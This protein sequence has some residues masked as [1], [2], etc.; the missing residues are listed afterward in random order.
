M[1]SPTT[2]KSKQ[3][4]KTNYKSATTQRTTTINIPKSKLSER[5]ITASTTTQKTRATRRK[6]ILQNQRFFSSK[7]PSISQ[8]NRDP[9][10]GALLKTQPSVITSTYT[11][12]E[13]P[14]YS[15]I[16]ATKKTKLATTPSP[17]LTNE[18]V[19][20]ATSKRPSIN[21]GTRVPFSGALLI[22]QPSVIT[23]STTTEPPHYLIIDTT[24]KT[25]LA[26]T[27]SPKLTNENV[28]KATTLHPKIQSKKDSLPIW[29]AKLATTPSQKL[30]IENV[31]KATFLYPNIEP[32]RDSFPIWSAWKEFGCK[33]D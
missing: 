22:T 32:K 9:F 18:N 7:R 15:I 14:H 2:P 30:T 31:R 1:P 13:S 24:K 8:G 11:T 21:Q 25:K 17:K 33:L 3:T 4:T 20:K 16:D 23:S 29:S 26:T 6:G 5:L 27:P 19:R 10:S 28:R 12:T